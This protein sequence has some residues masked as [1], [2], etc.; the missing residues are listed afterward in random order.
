MD[1]LIAFLNAQLDKDAERAYS[2][3]GRDPEGRWENMD[4]GNSVMTPRAVLADVAAKRQIIEFCGEREQHFVGLPG[5]LENPKAR[6]FLPGLRQPSHS[7]VLKFLALPYADHPDYREE[8][9][10]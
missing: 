6:D 10:P 5:A 4:E 2:G 7:M 3:W 1:D 9:K 8:W